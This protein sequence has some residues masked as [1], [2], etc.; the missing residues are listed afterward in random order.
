MTTSG[1]PPS[2]GH[3]PVPSIRSV[4][5]AV[6]GRTYSQSDLLEHFAVSDPK[7]VRLFHASGIRRRFLT[8]P[9]RGPEGCPPEESPGHLRAKHQR[10]ALDMGSRALRTCLDRAGLG[11]GQV[12]YLCC[13]TTTGLLTPGLSAL[14]LREMALPPTVERL[15]IVGM[16]CHAAMNGLAAARSWC[17]ANPGSVAVVVCAEVCSAAYVFDST[18]RTAV[19]NSLFGDGAAAVALAC[20]PVGAAQERKDEGRPVPHL[21]SSAS[22]VITSAADAMRYDWDDQQGRLSFFLTGGA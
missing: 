8:L 5:T 15:D 19:V 11:F 6:A 13:V 18:M 12:G 1:P 21:L 22:Q 9:V 17:V 14:L 2:S 7:V 10:V 16:G 3:R 4:G 20:R